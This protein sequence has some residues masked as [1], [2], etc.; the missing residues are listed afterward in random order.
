MNSR[1]EVRAP[2]E[3]GRT[4][5]RINRLILN[6]S[7]H[8]ERGPQ[9]KIWISWG[10]VTVKKNHCA[11][12]NYMIRGD[13]TFLK[14][15]YLLQLCTCKSQVVQEVLLD[16]KAPVYH[17]GKYP[18][19]YWAWWMFKCSQQKPPHTSF[20]SLSPMKL[21][22]CIANCFGTSLHH[23]HLFVSFLSLFQCTSC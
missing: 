1:Y 2:T 23:L 21:H 5:T 9:K 19:S 15:V 7:W 16:N 12:E 10:G 18:S 17:K 22:F 3:A 13:Q 11:A 4:M 8:P 6:S 20:I 14:W